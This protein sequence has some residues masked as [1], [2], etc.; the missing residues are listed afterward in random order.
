MRVALTLQLRGLSQSGLLVFLEKVGAYIRGMSFL[1]TKLAQNSFRGFYVA[2]RRRRVMRRGF[3]VVIIIILLIII[4]V[5]IIIIMVRVTMLNLGI[6]CGGSGTEVVISKRLWLSQ[7]LM[8]R[9]RRRVLEIRLTERRRRRR[10][11]S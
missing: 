6:V 10:S 3:E 1:L 9:F 2:E 5:I 11:V 7:R 4:T 8:I